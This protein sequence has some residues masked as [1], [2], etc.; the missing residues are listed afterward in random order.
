MLATEANSGLLLVHVG[1]VMQID[2]LK[3]FFAVTRPNSSHEEA[4]TV[5]YRLPHF[6]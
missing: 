4:T 5:G 3:L 2:C 1:G 6:Y